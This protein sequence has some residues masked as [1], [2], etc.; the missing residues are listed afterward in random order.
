M[1]K[2]WVVMVLVG[3]FALA[4]SA[5]IFE[6]QKNTVGTFGECVT[7]YLDTREQMP[8][9]PLPS[10]AEELLERAEKGDWSFMADKFWY[11]RQPQTLYVETDSE[12]AKQTK[13]R[14]PMKL[15]IMEDIRL[16]EIIL[17]SVD[18]KKGTWKPIASF[19]A[20]AIV[21][22]TD[23]E[24]A[25]LSSEEKSRELFFELSYRKIV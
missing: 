4:L 11:I 6:A 15:I 9:V 8:P 1:R 2:M 22:E 5:V 14:L 20:P 17:C 23:S 16:G 7:A 25:S 3:M 19:T 21:D 12:L 13:N 24:Y 18:E 10:S